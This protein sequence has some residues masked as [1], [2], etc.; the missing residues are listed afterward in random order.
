MCGQQRMKKN[1][2]MRYSVRDSDLEISDETAGRD[3]RS[4]KNN[5]CSEGICTYGTLFSEYGADSG[6]PGLELAGEIFFIQSLLTG[7]RI[8]PLFWRIIKWKNKL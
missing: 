3:R 2:S 6:M 8:L 4:G 7:C 5:R 1:G